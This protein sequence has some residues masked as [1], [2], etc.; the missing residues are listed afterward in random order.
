MARTASLLD[1]ETCWKTARA[2]R[3]RFLLDASGYFEL[4]RRVVRRARRSV[5][6]LA[7]DIDSRLEL[8]RDGTDDG[9]PV[10]LGPF[11]D[12]VVRANP[13]LHAHVLAWDPNMVYAL[14]RE[15]LPRVK[16]GWRT[17][18][19]L[20]FRLD[21]HHPTATSLHHKIVVVDDD[22]AFAGG[23]DLTRRR[24]DTPA[25]RAGDERRREPN[26]DR[27]PPF[28]DVH[29][30]VSGEAARALGDFVRERWRRAFGTRLDPPPAFVETLWP[31]DVDSEID[32][33]PVAFSRT[34]PE[35]DGRRPALE[36][37]RL[38]LRAI[39]EA[40]R[41]VYVENQYLTAPEIGDALRER[42]Q[43][44]N[45]P[46]V[47]IVSSRKSEG[48]FEH[49][50]MDVLRARLVK[51]LRD[52]AGEDRLRV[53]CPVAGNGGERVE[54]V[55]VHSKV[56]V[57]DDRLATV[58]SAN[59]TNRS[60]TI[61]SELDL[62]VVAS[63]PGREA[64]GIARF[65]HRLLADH[66]GREPDEVARAEAER[67]GTIAAIDALS[68][69]DR[70]LVPI[71]DAEPEAIDGHVAHPDLVDPVEPLDG[72]RL[73]NAMVPESSRPSAGRRALG[74]LAFPLALVALVVAWRFTPLKDVVDLES[75]TAYVRDLTSSFGGTILVA[76]GY[77]LLAMLG[78]PVMV[79]IVASALALGPWL[80]LALSFGGS[81][82]AA[83]ASFG[84]GRAMGSDTIR[85]FAGS[86]VNRMS[87]WLARRGFV[88]VAA[89]RVLPIAPFAVVNMVAGASHLRFRD[90]FLGSVVGM[91]PG[92]ILMTFFVDRLVA[93]A[94]EPSL[95]SI[96][97][98][99]GIV[100]LLVGATLLF[101]RWL[102][103]AETDGERAGA[104]AAS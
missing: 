90:F 5:L 95:V 39:R 28:H 76:G 2:S 1:E 63:G 11:L 72:P 99:A 88:T 103:R 45:G 41:V 55:V 70:T 8:V 46:E 12:A 47:V 30:M 49:M 93:A 53:L 14:E 81:M 24:W 100:A 29:L 73:L 96:L 13:D 36:I 32:D 9:L 97:I 82:T 20:T 52:A 79:L 38:A 6:V 4:F 33:V 18:R 89:V 17:H 102:R 80:G 56:L 75:V 31:E 16:L 66:L 84:L 85:R 65:R 69:G 60:L 92:M 74:L 21:G 91:T 44:E 26:G 68:G 27:Y 25:H 98:T 15:W 57:V 101:R 37:E 22:V 62:S 61:D 23:I 42:L 87:Q 3:L 43:E 58:G 77:L 7:W 10:R 86:R 48:W 83:A 67:G 54:P 40:E 64:E 34:E 59:F 104:G 51:K 19:R 71:A 35:F 78:F 94:T 50:T